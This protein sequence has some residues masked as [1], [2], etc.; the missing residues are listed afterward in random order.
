M[1]KT[2]IQKNRRQLD[3]DLADIDKRKYFSPAVYIFTKKFLESLNKYAHG[4][5]IDIGCGDTPYIKHTP[6]NVSQYDTFDVE[7][8]T[9]Q[10]TFIGNVMDMHMIENNTYDT[11]LCLAVLEHV[12]DPFT[13]VKEMHRILKKN[14]LFIL[15]APHIAR[16]HEEPHDYFR[17]THHGIKTLLEQNGFGI[18]ELEK[19]GTLLS[20]L[21]HQISTLILCLFWHIPILKHLIFFLNKVLI[22][23]PIAFIDQKIMQSSLIP[24]NYFCVAQKD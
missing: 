9:E 11:L 13:A 10:V 4:R 22:V 5:L 7:K 19:N 24:L 12:P 16:L 23:R 14:G 6:P 20:F 21:G 17:Y 3:I 15:S 18:I 8:R 1:I 2:L